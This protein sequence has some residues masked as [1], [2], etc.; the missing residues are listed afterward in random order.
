MLIAVSPLVISKIITVSVY[1]FIDLNIFHSQRTLHTME[2]HLQKE[3]GMFSA[4][5][6]FLLNFS[7]QVFISLSTDIYSHTTLKYFIHVIFLTPSLLT[8]FVSHACNLQTKCLLHELHCHS[9]SLNGTINE[10]FNGSFHAEMFMFKLKT[11][12]IMN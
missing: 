5:I 4:Y 6:L 11:N 7:M 3:K 10:S 2:K 1:Q 12:H 8:Q 9:A